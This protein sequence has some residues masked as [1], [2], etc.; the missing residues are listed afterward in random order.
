MVPRL[1]T[2][3]AGWPENEVCWRGELGG[4]IFSIIIMFSIVGVGTGEAVC[5][6]G[7]RTGREN[8][9]PG[10]EFRREHWNHSEDGNGHIVG[11]RGGG[12]GK[13]AHMWDGKHVGQG[14]CISDEMG[15]NGVKN[16]VGWGTRSMTGTFF[17]TVLILIPSHP[18]PYMGFLFHWCTFKTLVCSTSW[19]DWLVLYLRGTLI[20]HLKGGGP[21]HIPG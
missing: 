4:D 8:S 20:A 18:V 15:A 7:V 1:T 16:M 11:G 3:S 17:T 10:W 6:V 5:V 13:G 14:D 19:Y 21:N 2:E 12:M 9:T